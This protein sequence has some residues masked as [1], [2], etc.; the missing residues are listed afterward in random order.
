LKLRVIEEF[1]DR[2]DFDGIELDW[3]RHTLYFPRGTERENGRHLTALMR[4]VRKSLRERAARRGRPIEIAVRI[5]ERVEWCLEGGFE[6]PQWIEEDLCDVLI[7]GQGLTA[8]PG[9]AGFRKLMKRR[10]LPIYPCIYPYGNGYRISPDE[11]VRGS[12]ANLWRDGGDGL[13]TFNWFVY[14]T[15][16]QKLLA[17]VGDGAAFRDLD[18][19]YTLVERFE[20]TPREPGGDYIRY[21]T[22]FRDAPVP[23]TLNP[24]DDPKTVAIPVAGS[25]CREAQ[26]WIGMNYWKPGDVLSLSLNRKPL[27]S[28]DVEVGYHWRTA[29]PPMRLA[30]WN[31]MLG[32]PADPVVDLRFEALSLTVPPEL[33][34]EGQNQLTLKLK[35]RAAEA[36]KPLQVTRIELWTH[37]GAG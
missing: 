28:G 36:E 20:P 26:L 32:L 24:S 19:S 27:E 11:V 5:P 7:L 25:R 3:L 15:W 34:L 17:Q 1:F 21:N 13:Y 30:P 6:V 29:D 16:R 18:K 22:V 8:A 14:G 23:F 37:G 10:P 12:A 35:K 2:W 9:L 4:A 33:L 31:G